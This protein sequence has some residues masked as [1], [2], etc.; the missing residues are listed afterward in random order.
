MR[1]SMKVATV[2]AAG[3]LTLAGCG[4]A[5]EEGGSSSKGGSQSGSGSEEAVDTEGVDADYK[6]CM[7]SD[8]GGF[9]DQSFNQTSWAGME[10]AGEELGID[11]AKVE[12]Q[13]DADFAPNVD[14]LINQ[15]GCDLVVGVG[16]LLEDAIQEAAE[17]N[18]ETDFALVD[19][20]L[21]DAKGN[22]TE[23]DNVRP[24]LFN[25][26]EASFLAGYLS[27][28]MSES[29][30]VATFGGMEIPSVTVFMDGFADG[31]DKYNEDKDE[32]VKLLG[33]NKKSQKGSFSGDFENVS[34]GKTLTE[35]FLAQ[36]VDV[37]MPVAGPVGSGAAQA[38]EGKEGTKLVW[39]DT[40]GYESTEYG[41]VILTSVMKEMDEAVFTAILEGA[42]GE[43]TNEPYVGTLENEGVSIAPFHDFEAAVPAELVE[44]VDA[45]EEQIASGELK[46]ESEN[47]PK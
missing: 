2:L 13:S 20:A 4:E 36:G 32:K 22:P 41:K 10:R 30:K 18:P 26:A 11:V 40:D 19:A 34:Q 37:V 46:V 8:S 29:G 24:L 47:T 44:E 7:V 31:V 17:Q 28:G 15:Q 14:S 45:L 35:Q 6:A 21:A 42:K 39:V 12:S 27:A 33:W 43:F 23:A 3:A 1:V 5:P 16:F 25:T 38:V 9:N